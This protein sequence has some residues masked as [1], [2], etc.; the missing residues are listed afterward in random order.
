MSSKNYITQFKNY[1][2]ANTTEDAY[3]THTS[4]RGGRYC[5][6]DKEYNKFLKLYTKALQE[7]DKNELSLIERHKETS[8]IVI[9]LDF[10]FNNVFVL[11]IS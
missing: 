6:D 8:C 2:N 9:D 1:L 4:Y 10:R 11:N 7:D 3:V 5:I